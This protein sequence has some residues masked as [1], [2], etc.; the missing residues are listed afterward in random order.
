MRHMSNEGTMDMRPVQGF[1]TSSAQQLSCSDSDHE[2]PGTHGVIAGARAP[3]WSQNCLEVQL[4]G[5]VNK[6]PS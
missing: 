1:S 3:H 5:V 6:G 2:T 4:L